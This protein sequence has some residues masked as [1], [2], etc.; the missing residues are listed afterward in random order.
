M[1]RFKKMKKYLFFILIMLFNHVYGQNS[2][3]FTIS[4]YED[5]TISSAI[6]DNN[7]NFI[8]V[9]SIGDYTAKDKDAYVVKISA[10]GEYYSKRFE[11]QDSV[12]E[13]RSIVLLDDGNY[14][15]MG[16]YDV[17]TTERYRRNAW[18]CKLDSDLNLIYQKHFRINNFYYSALPDFSIIDQNGHI[19]T[20]GQAYHYTPSWPYST[21]LV[22]MKLTQQADTILTNYHRIDGNESMNGISLN[23]YNN[24]YSILGQGLGYFSHPQLTTL[25]SDLQIVNNKAFG[26]DIDVRSIGK[27]LSNTTFLVSG[28]NGYNEAKDDEFLYIVEM[29]TNANC[30]N[31]LVVNKEYFDDYAAW[32]YSN[33]YVNDTTIYIGGFTCYASP[34]ITTPNIIEILLID[35]Q[36]NLLGYIDYETKAYSEVMGI[37]PC[38]DGGCFL[39]SNFYDNTIGGQ[40]RDLHLLKITRNDINLVTSLP[41]K[42]QSNQKVSIQPNPVGDMLNISITN[43]NVVSFPNSLQIFDGL[44][45]TIFQ[46]HLSK[47]KSS[48]NVSQLKA[49]VYYYKL[50]GNKTIE[51]G[52]FIKM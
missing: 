52:K 43:S 2:F 42:I 14:L 37:L 9:G 26:C 39:Y 28:I 8:L 21:D 4:S 22:F 30:L 36:L 49:G 20:A 5:I 48:I 31:E 24:G 19:V 38:S 11:R 33:A 7:G 51:S 3:D 15:A 47:S 10:E 34:W 25:T 40:E 41:E 16:G 35:S 29:D 1:Q 23:P 17:D 44:G 6:E 46:M 27:W 18:F 50:S 45:K 32:K 13:F 12:S